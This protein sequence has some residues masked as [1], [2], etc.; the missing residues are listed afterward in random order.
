M[1]AEQLDQFRRRLESERADA[2]RRVGA[3]QAEAENMIDREDEM[4]VQAA[5]SH[6]ADVALTFA[7][8]ET[9]RYAAID[10]ALGRIARGEYGVCED[11]GEAIPLARLELQPTA[12]RDTDCQERH[13]IGRP[14]TL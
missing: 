4:E 14:P 5:Q 12:T 2:N 7:E 8:R 13:E 9:H 1:D 11:C 6:D 10:A 3:H